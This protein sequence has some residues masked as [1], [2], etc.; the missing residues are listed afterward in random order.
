MAICDYQFSDESNSDVTDRLK[1]MLD[2][3]ITKDDLDT[4][5]ETLTEIR[6]RDILA[7][8]KE[9]CFCATTWLMNVAHQV[10]IYNQNKVLT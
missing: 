2:I 6:E 7:G 1:E 10:G 3:N 9:V 4:R 5:Q 8:R